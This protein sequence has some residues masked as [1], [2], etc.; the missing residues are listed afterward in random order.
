MLPR[1]LLGEPW[2]GGAGRAVEFYPRLNENI[3]SPLAGPHFLSGVPSVV[4]VLVRCRPSLRD[5]ISAG[6]PAQPGSPCKH[7]RPPGLLS[8]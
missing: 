2:K 1:E 5:A 3:L 4:V 6:G 8:A 7:F